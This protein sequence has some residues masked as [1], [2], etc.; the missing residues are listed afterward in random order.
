MKYIKTTRIS[1]RRVITR[2]ARFASIAPS[3]E[4]GVAPCSEI[5]HASYQRQ[6]YLCVGLITR[7]TSAHELQRQVSVWGIAK[8]HNR[9]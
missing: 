5:E 3:L 9:V 6:N 8:I 7:Q 1:D 4:L 2:Y